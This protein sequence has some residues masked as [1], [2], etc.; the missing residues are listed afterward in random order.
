M[1]SCEF[2]EISKNT[3]FAE[4]LSWLLLVL[5]S[6]ELWTYFAEQCQWLWRSSDQR[7]SVKKVPLEISQNSQENTCATTVFFLVKLQAWGQQLYSKRDSLQLY[8]KETLVSFEFCEI[9]KNTF[10][11]NTS[12]GLL[13]TLGFW[14]VILNIFHSQ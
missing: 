9:S 3:F 10:L 11:Q 1:F 6:F 7:C 4:H 13:L 5:V 14:L 2:W 8:K 12:G